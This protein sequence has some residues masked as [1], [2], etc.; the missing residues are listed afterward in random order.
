MFYL[1]YWVFRLCP[2]MNM[3]LFIYFCLFLPCI[4]TYNV[5]EENFLKFTGGSGTN[6]G[7][8]TA[9]LKN[10]EGVWL[11]AGAPKAN[12][13]NNPSITTPGN[14]YKCLVNLSSKEQRQCTEISNLRTG[15]TT[16]TRRGLTN[17][18]D[19]QLL[20]AN[21]LVTNSSVV[22]CSSLWKNV[23]YEVSNNRTFSVGY[24]FDI[25]KSNIDIVT[26]RRFQDL[27]IGSNLVTS[28]GFVYGL[29]QLGFSTT[30]MT[31]HPDFN[32]VIGGP[33]VNDGKGGFVLANFNKIGSDFYEAFKVED[34]ANLF[35]TTSRGSYGGYAVGAGMFGSLTF[36]RPLVVIGMPRFRTQNEGYLG[37]VIMLSVESN[38][39]K[40]LKIL[41]GDQTGSGY[42]S[43][44]CISDINGDGKDDLLVGAPY[45]TFGIGKENLFECGKVYVYY[46]TSDV[47]YIRKQPDLLNLVGSKTSKSRFG[48][49]IT[50]V[51][52]I[53]ADSFNDIA[54][55]APYEDELN[56]AIY[57]YNGRRGDIHN[58]YSQRIS[59]RRFQPK[60]KAFGMHISNSF[61]VDAN[62]YGVIDFDVKSDTVRTSARKSS[63]LLLFLN[64]E[65]HGDHLS[66]TKFRVKNT[67]GYSCVNITGRV[68]AYFEGEC[69]GKCRSNLNLQMFVLEPAAR[70]IVLGRTKEIVLRVK[71]I[72]ANQPAYAATVSLQISNY[73]A[74]LGSQ[75]NEGSRGVNCKIDDNSTLADGYNVV[76]CDILKPLYQHQVVDFRIRINVAMDQLLPC[77]RCYDDIMST[78]H[79]KAFVDTT[80]SIEEDE[81]DNR[82]SYSFPIQ[83]ISKLELNGI[84]EPEQY[85]LTE[86]DKEYLEFRH[87]Y[88]VYNNGPSPLPF[89]NIYLEIP[90]KGDNTKSFVNPKHI[91]IEPSLDD[92]ECKFFGL[93]GSKEIKQSTQ[94]QSLTLSSS[95]FINTDTTTLQ[96]HNIPTMVP[97]RRRREAAP[98]EPIRKQIISNIVCITIKCHI[99]LFRRLRVVKRISA[100]NLNVHCYIWTWQKKQPLKSNLSVITSELPFDKNDIL[101]RYKTKAEVELPPHNLFYP[102]NTGLYYMTGFFKRK[103]PKGFKE[104]KRETTIRKRRET[105]RR[106][107]SQRSTST[108]KSSTKSRWEPQEAATFTKASD[109]KI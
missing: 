95:L 22:A 15:E 42:G 78:V 48:L 66:I 12:F 97:Q 59:G 2:L 74:Y 54:I 17:E 70:N 11:L 16:K 27:E 81:Q 106:R 31:Q 85:K 93:V 71:V 52:D 98:P 21:L 58:I 86:S 77:D 7:F 29:A 6:F 13:S 36:T 19:H 1:D 46:G 24:C 90:F 18:E 100:L 69:V 101:L 28:A 30:S 25:N 92:S 3:D 102:W 26:Q 53:N 4:W 61:D 39:L 57:I 84:S 108:Q 82:I 103:Q 63:R 47:N 8:S 79:V 40:S 51:G 67:R 9:L 5:D 107:Q 55:G 89:T 75:V 99:L 20:G 14:V 35:N 88:S 60:L 50:S 44:I 109:N 73:T 37:A 80:G 64:N 43:T 87:E 23:R 34:E 76:I 104:W 45:Y 68:Q 83:F 41:A 56:G 32:L 96:S 91:S 62:Q 94:T 105:I 72:N 49:A 10:N 65:N 38:T 33:G